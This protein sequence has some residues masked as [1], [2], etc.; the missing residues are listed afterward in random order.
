MIKQL[1]SEM[2]R[3]I[4]DLEHLQ[5]AASQVASL[6]GVA[7]V[8]SLL[9]RDLSAW[10]KAYPL[11][12]ICL[13]SSQTELLQ[14]QRLSLGRQLS[15]ARDRF[16][17]DYSAPVGLNRIQQSART[18]LDDT[19]LFWKQYAE[20][21]IG[22][23]RGQADLARRLPQMQREMVEID[24]LYQT[25]VSMSSRLPQDASDLTRFYGQE[26]QLRQKLSLVEGLSPEQT[27]F[28]EKVRRGSA[29]VSD[30][31]EPLLAWCHEQGLAGL[32]RIT[33]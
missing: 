23:L 9:E 28:L 24:R 26:T 2:G 1:V 33:F 30:L 22:P 3:Q 7:N 21:R 17:A 18:L 15:Q 13:S 11:I 6:Q 12:K 29:T 5:R 19:R 8:L 14:Q 10:S 32:L 27:A 31:A 16:A 25:L 4:E 20:E